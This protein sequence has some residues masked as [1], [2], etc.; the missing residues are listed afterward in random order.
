MKY[1]PV[2]TAVLTGIYHRDTLYIMISSLIVLLTSHRLLAV[3]FGA[4]FFGDSVILT[5]AYIA[6]QESW[7]VFPILIA[8]FLGT[9]TADTLWFVA[10]V[11]IARRFKNLTFMQKEREKAAALLDMLAGKNPLYALIF[12]KFLY[13]SRVAMI[14]YSASRGISFPVFTL[15]NSIGIATW[16]AVFFP[17]GYLSGRG[18]EMALPSFG[19]VQST[20]AVFVISVIVMRIFTLWLTKKVTNA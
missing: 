13:G 18:V 16:L 10:G 17:L 19:G 12:I 6:G 3:F 14:L 20:I 15:Y 2:S 4:F 7:T 1:I 11:L 9:A 8:V 5:T